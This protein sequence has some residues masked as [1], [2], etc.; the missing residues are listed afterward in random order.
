M[1]T[2]RTLVLD[3][4]NRFAKIYIVDGDNLGGKWIFKRANPIWLDKLENI[5]INSKCKSGV[6][7]SVVPELTEM[8]HNTIEKSGID[9]L[10]VGASIDLPLEIDYGSPKRLGADRIAD[11][12]GA[13]KFYSDIADSL[14][15]VDA[16]TAITIDLIRNNK[17]LGGAILPGFNMMADSLHSGTAQL[18][19]PDS[20]I[21]PQFPGKAT[22][23]CISA[24]AIAAVVGACE[25]L[26]KK[27]MSKTK[28][29]KLILTGGDAKKITEFINLEYIEDPLLLVKGAVA[30]LDNF[31]MEKKNV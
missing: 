6:I 8:A 31:R 15:V 20:K 1:K 29:G 4:G 25:F 10:I 2:E 7:V 21:S 14:M 9:S 28:T 12:I 24:G 19:A 26:W 16:G 17:F 30:I 27:F 5:A 13:W 22:E 23:Q 3:I 18:P 11:A